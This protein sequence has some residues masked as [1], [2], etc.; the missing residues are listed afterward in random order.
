MLTLTLLVPY[1][2]NR[3]AN[4]CVMTRMRPSYEEVLR[5][6]PYALVRY[7]EYGHD[8]FNSCVLFIPGHGG[9][10]QQ[11]RSL[12]SQV[13]LDVYAVD[14]AGDLAAFNGR[15]LDRQ[16]SFVTKCVERLKNEYHKV[17][18]V[19]HSVGGVVARRSPADGVVT[20]A[21]PLTH[22]FAADPSLVAFFQKKG[23]RVVSISGGPRD[24]QVPDWLAQRGTHASTRDIGLPST[25]HQCALWC[26][27]LV[28][29]LARALEDASRS[30][31]TQK[32]L[33]HLLVPRSSREQGPRPPTLGSARR[34]L[35]TRRPAVLA[36]QLAVWLLPRSVA[37]AAASAVDDTLFWVP[38]LAVVL[39]EIVAGSTLSDSLLAALLVLVLER[40]LAVLLRRS[41]ALVKLKRRYVFVAVAAMALTGSLFPCFAAA[42]LVAREPVAA[43]LFASSAVALAPT[44]VATVAAAGDL[45]MPDS[46]DIF[47]AI[48]P[49]AS[50]ALVPTIGTTKKLPSVVRWLAASSCAFAAASGRPKLLLD[51][52]FIW[53]ISNISICI[54]G[55]P[56]LWG[57]ITRFF[58]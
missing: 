17:L 10:F 25:D 32:R 11:V 19:G 2:A 24:W 21:A 45:P 1:G 41:S 35:E 48:A 9:S 47:L 22:P 50:A 30:N 52:S 42:A 23:R 36:S 5:G 8:D 57:T 16:L 33:E 40:L 26:N 13:M 54:M 14:I 46:A 49:L 37:L 34:F 43:A 53:A 38:P 20:L 7:R 18:V 56:P 28:V 39:V 29:K 58:C 44:F 31:D 27:Q 12:G 51:C 3:L 15:L 55:H 4:D 6:E